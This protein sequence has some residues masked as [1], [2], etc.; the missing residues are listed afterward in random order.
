MMKTLTQSP[1]PWWFR[2]GEC[3]RCKLS[4][5]QLLE[6]AMH[7]TLCTVTTSAKHELMT[8]L[9]LVYISVS[10]QISKIYHKFV[11]QWICGKTGDGRYCILY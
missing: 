10:L 2:C 7:T 5:H 6:A 11:C 3:C 8:G 1:C 4:R 9:E